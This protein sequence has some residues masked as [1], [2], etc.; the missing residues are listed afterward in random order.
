MER[1]GVD[2]MKLAPG[3]E[4]PVRQNL[5]G[6]YASIA[7]PALAAALRYPSDSKNPEYAPA[8]TRGPKPDQE[9]D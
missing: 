6:Q 3:R 4:T 9:T 2:A 5:D 8:D 1:K 7:M